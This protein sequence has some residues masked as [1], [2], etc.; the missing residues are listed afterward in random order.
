MKYDYIIV[1]CGYAGAICARL[2]AEKANKRILLIE[3]RD[4][5]AGNMFDY[6]DKTGIVV[7]KY[8]P[9]ISKMNNKNVLNFLSLY[10]DWYNYE[11]Y[12]NA[13]VEI[14]GTEAE[15]PLPVNF[16]GMEIFFD[17]KFKKI[18]TLL[19]ETY[20]DGA[21]VP[22]L[23]MRQSRD[24][25]IR[26]CAEY[27]Y[28]KIFVYYTAKKW[29]VKPEQLDLLDISLTG[30]MPIRLSYDNRFFL[31]KYQVM[32]KYGFTKLF[33]NLLD[34]ANIDILLNTSASKV[35]TL[36]KKN[37]KVL[38][39]NKIY[40]GCLIYTG[41]VDELFD[42]EL[43]FLPY[44]SASFEMQYFQQDYIQNVATVTWPDQRSAMRRTEMKRLSCQHIPGITLTS[45]E[46]SGA[47]FPDDKEFNE[48]YY[49]IL[50]V[51]NI[52]LYKKYKNLIM[53]FDNI[54]VIGRL[55][56][57]K[58]YDMETVIFTTLQFLSDKF[59]IS[60]DPIEIYNGHPV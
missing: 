3:R 17:Q 38:Y 16:T 30:I 24:A 1:G 36:D 13:I 14:D 55:G 20:G 57:Y 33:R 6:T 43:G 56:E 39:Q 45:T 46:F 29:G 9:H 48:P 59:N 25:T 26:D 15:I 37:R 21:V 52:N 42:Y 32:P 27:I 58:Y 51:D 53:G 11:Q 50:N 31:H 10:T 7:Q 40:N 28:D 19:L 54:F 47:Y 41:T 5:I 2:L 60:Y 44:R 49:P 4:T 34:H 18:K 23:K 8:G 12:S 35:L 22:I